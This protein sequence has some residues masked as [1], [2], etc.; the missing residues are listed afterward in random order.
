M[1]DP[2]SL[3]DMLRALRAELQQSQQAAQPEDLKFLLQ[4]LEVEVQFTTSTKNAGGAGVKFWV[5]NA[6][7]KTEIASQTVHKV[8]LR[9]DARNADNTDVTIGSAPTPKPK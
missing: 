7:A 5:V 6:D 1:D 8:K 2:L 4:D 3:A 9:L